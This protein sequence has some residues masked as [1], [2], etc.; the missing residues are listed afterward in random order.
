MDKEIDYKDLK[1]KVI[2]S[3]EEFELDDLE[4]PFVLFNDIKNGKIKLEEARNTQ[5]EYKKYF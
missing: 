5:K 2:S 3:G 1:Y 4:N